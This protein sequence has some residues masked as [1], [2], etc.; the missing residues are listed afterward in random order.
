MPDIAPQAAPESP[1]G[2][3]FDEAIAGI[4]AGGGDGSNAIVQPAPELNQPAPE[5]TSEQVEHEIPANAAVELFRQRGY[6]VGDDFTDDALF[7]AIGQMHQDAQ[8]FAASRDG[9]DQYLSQKEQFDAWLASQSAPPVQEPAAKPTGKVPVVEEPPV[10]APSVPKLDPLAEQFARQGLLQKNEKGIWVATVDELKPYAAKMAEHDAAVAKYWG[11]LESD[12][13]SFAWAHMFPRLTGEL[14]KRDEQINALQKQVEELVNARTTNEVE[15][16]FTR[17]ANDYYV[18]DD[19]GQAVLEHGRPKLTPKGEA[20][21]RIS[22]Y[23]EKTLGIKDQKKRH[24]TTLGLLS[25]MPAPQAAPSPAP[26]QAQPES[27]APEEKKRT[28]LQKSAANG[29]KPVNG[30]TNRLPTRTVPEPIP[31]INV[32]GRERTDWEALIAETAASRR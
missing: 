16:Y 12:F 6:E 7:E 27:P 2:N 3:A 32:K 1:A 20:Y 23:V 21:A 24:E 18:L 9:F 13:G 11:Q 8:Q 15:T 31:T 4:Q 22:S 10:E 25:A 26:Q 5:I 19:K 29:H 14:S 28:F 30:N 17:T